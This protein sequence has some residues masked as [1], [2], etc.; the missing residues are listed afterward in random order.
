[1]DSTSDLLET[2]IAAA[3]AAGDLQRERLGAPGRIQSKQGIEVLTEVDLACERLITERIR[4]RFP[5]HAILA[6]ESG[7][8]DASARERWIVDPL[9]G[10][11]NFAHGFP[12]FASSVAFARDRQVLVAACDVPMWRETFWAARGQGAFLN[13]QRLHVSETGELRAA[14]LATGFPYDLHLDPRNNLAHFAHLA[15]RSQAVR[16]AGAAVVDLCF[17]AAGRFDGFWEFKLRPWDTAAAALVVR[18]AGGQVT[19]LDGGPWDPWQGAIVA[20]NGR[21]HGELLTELA[22][23]EAA[24]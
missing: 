13:G 4:G 18:E 24:G 14:L 23:V 7:D 15:V 9:D 20:S 22:C 1:M 8:S 10:T 11:T 5:D 12:V 17:V 2:A 21:I 16:R 6:E 19:A 3:R